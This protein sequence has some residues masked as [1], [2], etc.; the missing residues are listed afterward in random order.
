MRLHAI[1]IYWEK[2]EKCHIHGNKNLTHLCNTTMR[3]VLLSLWSNA[4]TMRGLG[5]RSLG[6]GLGARLARPNLFLMVEVFISLHF[7]S[8]VFQ[9]HFNTFEVSFSCGTPA[10]DERIT[11]YD[12]ALSCWPLFGVSPV[13][14]I[15]TQIGDDVVIRCCI[16]SMQVGLPSLDASSEMLSR[17]KQTQIS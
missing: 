10:S 15:K 5:T 14:F 13:V 9:R 12:L 1:N 4:G 16:L 11:K 7:H 8:E 2:H 17:S 6:T 3:A